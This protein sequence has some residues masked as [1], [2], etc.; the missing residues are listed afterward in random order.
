MKK[1]EREGVRRAR[2]DEGKEKW[3]E[4]KREI[5]ESDGIEGAA[6]Q[7]SIPRS[8]PEC[9]GVNAKSSPR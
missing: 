7:P 2:E 4:M 1:R 3:R 6:V 5:E 9:W 8:G